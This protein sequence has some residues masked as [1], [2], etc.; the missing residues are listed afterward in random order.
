MMNP[1]N[2]KILTLV[3]IVLA[4]FVIWYLFF[5]G[6]KQ[7]KSSFGFSFGVVTSTADTI[8]YTI[9]QSD[10]AKYGQNM[11]QWG[12]KGASAPVAGT[13][14]GNSPSGDSPIWFT[15]TDTFT[16]GGNP[17][18]LLWTGTFQTSDGTSVADGVQF[19]SGVSLG[20][21][22]MTVLNW[23]MNQD[24]INAY[25]SDKQNDGYYKYQFSV[26]D[27]PVLIDNT[28]KYGT[29][30]NLGTYAPFGWNGPYIGLN[31]DSVNAG[32]LGTN[33]W[34]KTANGQNNTSAMA[35][36]R[37]V[38]FLTAIQSYTQLY[39]YITGIQGTAG[40]Y[41]YGL[42]NIQDGNNNGYNASGATTSSGLSGPLPSGTTS[43]GGIKISKGAGD[44]STF[45][46]AVS[47]NATDEA[48]VIQNSAAIKAAH[49]TYSTI[50]QF[51]GPTKH[52]V[53]S[54]LLARQNQLLAR[55]D[56]LIIGSL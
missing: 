39:T 48:G 29:L 33:Q 4:I 55:L 52:A 12:V 7:I 2:K 17:L 38:G 45:Y 26:I 25:M 41:G 6:A 13:G 18:V 37:T 49:N 23:Y 28:G 8:K 47:P 34:S 22:Q 1:K 24:S 19:P 51:D 21:D 50:F 35:S 42:A 10:T 9:P 3:G 31:I 5:G 56:P 32:G 46:L 20:N 40:V 16:T 53:W 11:I 27:D 15:N 54:M 30:I 44:D 43:T 14:T 36:A